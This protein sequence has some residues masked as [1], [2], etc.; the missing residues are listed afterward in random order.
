MNST[1][2]LVRFTVSSVALTLT[3]ALLGAADTPPAAPA[4]ELPTSVQV[5]RVEFGRIDPKVALSNRARVSRDFTAVASLEDAEGGLRVVAGG[6]PGPVYKSIYAL[7]FAPAGHRWSCEVSSGSGQCAVMVDGEPGPV[8]ETADDVTWSADG[9]HYLYRVRRAS[10]SAWALVFDGQVGDFQSGRIAVLALSPDGAHQVC[11]RENETGQATLAFYDGR[12]FGETYTGFSYSPFKWSEDGTLFAAVAKQGN[13]NVLV[14][15]REE[16]ARGSSIDPDYLVLSKD[17]R[18]FAAVVAQGTGG[19]LVVHD[20]RHLGPYKDVWGAPALAPDGA[21]VAFVAT[22]DDDLAHAVIDGTAGPAASTRY[23]VKNL[24][25]SGDGRVV[26]YLRQTGA[27]QF[28]IQ[29]GDRTVI[30]GPGI[31]RL[32]LSPDGSSTAWSVKAE[33]G[34]RVVV[35]GNATEPVFRD[36][37]PDAARFSPDGRT[38]LYLATRDRKSSTVRA[39]GLGGR[40]YEVAAPMFT[41]PSPGVVT[42]VSYEKGAFARETWKLPR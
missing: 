5:E 16:R 33:N 21:R 17:G 25:F 29:V 9:R 1:P 39:T 26:G 6:V 8:F 31:Q 18:H 28:A 7:N 13:E 20:A 37:E 42:F 3:A 4:D 14:V 36:V 23:G 11:V 34:V 32:W 22:L 41:F 27:D 19:Y 10:D 2:R 30:E 15:N 38:F 12:R 35:N 24:Q 40:T